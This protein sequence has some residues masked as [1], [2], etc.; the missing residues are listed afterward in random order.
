MGDATALYTIVLLHH[1][2]IIHAHGADNCPPQWPMLADANA[3]PAST[4]DHSS[5]V[6]VGRCTALP[7]HALAIAHCSA[8]LAN[9]QIGPYVC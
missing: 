1:P 5:M 8:N 7:M 2:F 6:D 4:I 9:F 3:A